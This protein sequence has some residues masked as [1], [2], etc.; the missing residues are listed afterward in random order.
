MAEIKQAN[1]AIK[2]LREKKKRI[3][4]ALHTFL[5]ESGRDAFKGVTLKQVQPKN[6]PKMKPKAIREH[7]IKDYLTKQG[8][9]D[10]DLVYKTMDAMKKYK[11]DDDEYITTNFPLQR[12]PKSKSSKPYFD[13][14]LGIY[15]E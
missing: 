2:V 8:V 9:R 14:E 4:H 15:V 5:A 13:K 6:R 7:E 10:P 3:D 12:K 1:D 11:P